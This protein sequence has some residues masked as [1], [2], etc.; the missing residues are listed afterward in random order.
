MPTEQRREWIS[1]GPDPLAVADVGAWVVSPRCGA[2]VTFCG[3]VRES[4]TTGQDIVALEYDTSDDLA[5]TRIREVIAELRRRWPDVEA[6][7]VHHR[8]GRVELGEVTVV[9]AVSAPHRQEAFAAG[10]FCIDAVKATVPM[11]KRE[12][13]EGGSAWSAEATPIADVGDR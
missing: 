6:V 13:W 12:I 7:A 3:T 11:W 1:V 2:T 5:H 8:T 9:V 10:Q 4:S